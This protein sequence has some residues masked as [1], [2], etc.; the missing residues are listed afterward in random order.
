M[1]SKYGVTGRGGRQAAVVMGA[2]GLSLAAALPANASAHTADAGSHLLG[3]SVQSY[4]TYDRV[5]LNVSSIPGYTVT[6]TD[7]LTR[8]GSGKDVTLPN[9]NTYLNV[10]L[11]PSD[12]SGFSGPTQITTGDPEVAAVAELTSFEGYTQ[13]GIGLDH[14][15]SYTVTVLDSTHLAIDVAH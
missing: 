9:S 8:D 10:E 7:E 5:I 3:L 2:I 14:A 13:V 15:S 6:P 12:I 1:L 4:S 11:N